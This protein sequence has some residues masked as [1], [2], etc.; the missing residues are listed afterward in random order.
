L[1][2]GYWHDSLV[3]F[4]PILLIY[5]LTMRREERRLAQA[6]GPRWEAYVAQTPRLLPLRPHSYQP[7]RW[8]LQQWRKSREYRAAVSGLVAL[9][10]LEVGRLTG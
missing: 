7:G 3:I 4:G 1:V 9:L 8:T 10:A 2:I 6:Y 5:L